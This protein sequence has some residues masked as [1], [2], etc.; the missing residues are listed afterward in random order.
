MTVAFEADIKINTKWIQINVE[1]YF[2]GYLIF[3]VIII[4]IIFF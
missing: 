3:N 2:I 1:V 4:I